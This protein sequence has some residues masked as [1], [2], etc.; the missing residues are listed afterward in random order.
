LHPPC[1]FA[2]SLHGWQE[3]GNE[4]ADDGDDDEEFYESKADSTRF[5]SLS[6]SL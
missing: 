4:Y 6:L 5:L 3:E 1:G 2:G